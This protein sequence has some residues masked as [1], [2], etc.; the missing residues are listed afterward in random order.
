[1]L[2]KNQRNRERKDFDTPRRFRELRPGDLY[3]R[4]QIQSMRRPANRVRFVFAYILPSLGWR[5][6]LQ[7]LLSLL[8]VQLARR[9]YARRAYAHRAYA[10]R[11]YARLT[12]LLETRM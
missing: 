10:R 2:V 12:E 6:V 9:A 8:A 11:A 1:M 3:A 4:R 7:Y 5:Q